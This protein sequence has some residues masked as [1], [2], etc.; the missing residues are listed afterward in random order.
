MKK[1]Q[2]SKTGLQLDSLLRAHQ[3]LQLVLKEHR[4]EL[5]GLTIHEIFSM[6]TTVPQPVVELQT[7]TGPV[8]KEMR[9]LDCMEG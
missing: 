7:H 9:R 2:I 6:T 1:L 5:C 8:K 3:Q 4:F